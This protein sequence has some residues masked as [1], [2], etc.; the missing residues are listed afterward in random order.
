MRP[1]SIFSGWLTQRMKVVFPDPDGPM[2]QTTSRGW[3]SSETPFSTSSRPKR[4][5]T[6][7]AL[8]T[9]PFVLIGQPLPNERGKGRGG[10]GNREVPPA[11][12]QRRG[13]VGKTW[14][15]PRERAK[16]ERR[17]RCAPDAHRGR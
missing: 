4:L 14:F 2:M 7:S 17:S 8:M 5:T 9:G 16:G 1:E 12:H 13:L 6:F 11:V 10:R 15:P 3:T